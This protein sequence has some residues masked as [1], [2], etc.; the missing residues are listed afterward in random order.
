V[1]SDL[2]GVHVAQVV[3]VQPRA[4]YDFECYVSTDKLETGSSPQIQILDG[5]TNAELAL[6]PM[7]PDGTSHW[8]RVNLSF[9]TSDKTEAVI[10]KIL[11]N[12]CS[13]KETP[14]CPIYGSVWYD[15]F[16]IK[17]RN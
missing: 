5:L 3:P 11:R 12:S 10:L 14:V 13:T 17:R 8:N 4:Q 2:N 6:S 15:D 16:S 7:A 9:K 1:R